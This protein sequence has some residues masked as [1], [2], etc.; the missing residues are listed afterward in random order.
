MN[1]NKFLPCIL[2]ASRIGSMLRKRRTTK[3]E[4]ATLMPDG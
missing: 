3:V 2:L 4:P 1:W